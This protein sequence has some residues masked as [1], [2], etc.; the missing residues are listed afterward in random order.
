MGSSLVAQWVKDQ[1]CHC[2]GMAWVLSLATEL[3]NAL[4]VAKNNLK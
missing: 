1:H 4:G 3:L 2:Y